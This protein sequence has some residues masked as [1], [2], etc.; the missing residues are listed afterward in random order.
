[1]P[2][3]PPPSPAARLG[4][5]RPVAAHEDIASFVRDLFLA[6]EHR[7]PRRVLFT[8]LE[9]S[10]SAA[11]VV[12][13]IATLLA[14]RWSGPVYLV[15]MDLHYPSL[16]LRFGLA[17]KDGFAGALQKDGGLRDFSYKA[18]SAG[19]LWVMPAGSP[20]GALPSARTAVGAGL[21]VGDAAV[22]RRIATLIDTPA[23]VIAYTAAIGSYADAELIGRLFDGVV[24]VVQ[25]GDTA[26]EWTRR[27]SL[28]LERSK[29]T[30][31]GTI[32]DQHVSFL[33]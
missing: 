2:S 11:D 13:Q 6:R 29:A 27:A 16:H 15:D 28:A 19:D 32:R 8:S 9:D 7:S 4:V 20:M 10:P 25:P 22:Q 3:T 30:V 21:G 23:H 31:L 26:A 17:D 18:E 12:V 1:M 14:G 5:E 24:L 33:V